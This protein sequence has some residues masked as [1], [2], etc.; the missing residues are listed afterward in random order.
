TIKQVAKK[1][2]SSGLVCTDTASTALV[3]TN[4]IPPQLSV[5]PGSTCVPYTLQA[6]AT[7]AANA[8]KVEWTF[9]DSAQAPYIF[10]ATGTSAAHL[11][12][13]AGTYSVKLLVRTTNE[14]ADSI[15]YTF[16]VYN[17]P[18]VQFTPI[19][20]NTC[21]HDTTIAF[22]AKVKYAGTDAVHLK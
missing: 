22:T 13:K 9:Y 5:Q 19:N 7:G 15:T 17:T 1:V 3:V 4:K 16:N 14:C 11:Y 20:N 12:N 18:V 2:N 6:A 10:T 8:L 21:N